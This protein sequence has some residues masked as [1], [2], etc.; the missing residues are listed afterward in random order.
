MIRVA[1]LLG[2]G[3]MCVA[4]FFIDTLPGKLCA[5]A[6]LLLLTVQALDLKAYNL[7]MLNVVGVAGYSF[8]LM[9]A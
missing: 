5:I 6:G 2:T 3:A 9:G 1:A 8:S 7:I 4:P